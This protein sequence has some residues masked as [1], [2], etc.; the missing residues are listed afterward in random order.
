MLHPLH[1]SAAQHGRLCVHALKT[2]APG[3]VRF[4]KSW[5]ARWSACRWS[6]TYVE[7]MWKICW[8]PFVS[9]IGYMSIYWIYIWTIF[10]GQIFQ[11]Y[12][13]MLIQICWHSKIWEIRPFLLYPRPPLE[14]N[15][16]P[17]WD[18]EALATPG[19]V[20]LLSCHG[21]PTNFHHR[22]PKYA[23]FLMEC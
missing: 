4:A 14:G 15:R 7:N 19:Q 5:F 21:F 3:R 6:G 9:A 2:E 13:K 1:L 20:E 8:D 22:F 17:V 23:N 11:I 18:P 12:V 16:A 10:N